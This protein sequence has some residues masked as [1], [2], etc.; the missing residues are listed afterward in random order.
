M[1]PIPSHLRILACAFSALVG[2]LVE[3]RPG[4]AQPAAA[5]AS[6]DGFS[7]TLDAAR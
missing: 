7:W 1:T 4:I 6:Q 3:P 2:A 5:A